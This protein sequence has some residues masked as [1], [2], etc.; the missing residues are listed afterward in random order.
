MRDIKRSDILFY[1]VAFVII[2][3]GIFLRFKLY[4]A[5]IPFWLDE[6]MLSLSFID[7]DILGMFMPLEAIQKSPPIFN[8]LVFLCVKFFG[9]N[10]L[11]LRFIPFFCSLISVILFFSLLKDEIK[12]RL[13]VL[14]GIFIFSLNLPLIYY[15]QEFKQY[16][17]DVM[18]CILLIYLYKYISFKDLNIKKILKYS[19]FSVLIILSS[20]PAIF[21]L[22]SVII[23]KCIEEKVLNL[24]I[25]SIVLSMF[26]PITY[27]YL[28][29]KDMRINEIQLDAWQ[30]G[31]INFSFNSISNMLYDVFSFLTANWS[32]NYYLYIILFI[33][34]G[35]IIYFA[36]KNKKAYL[37]LFIL[38]FVFLASL[39][40]IYPISSRVA[41]YL[42][43]IIIILM[44]KISDYPP[45]HWILRCNAEQITNIFKSIIILI[46]LFN[47]MHSFYIPYINVSEEETINFRDPLKRRIAKKNITEYFLNN[48][49]QGDLVLSIGEVPE[50]WFDFYIKLNNKHKEI[51]FD[52]ENLIIDKLTAKELIKEFI[53]RKQNSWIVV[54]DNINDILGFKRLTEDILKENKIKYKHK[55]ENDINLYYIYF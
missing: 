45:P 8:V 13:V 3:L 43:P 21:I 37:I 44:L 11:S 54:N 38:I 18:F 23:G 31:F 25:L 20:F 29:Y 19:I 35:M 24:K 48:Y 51:T 34:F 55:E 47:I 22:P 32:F 30:S 5:K 6:M 7:R 33:L 42:L 16:S 50:I 1:I 53:K 17:C 46:L 9:F 26:F 28:L 39:F 27:L 14:A 12:S 52:S 4:F 15:C 41:L 2:I 40:K 36:E 10:I 49:K